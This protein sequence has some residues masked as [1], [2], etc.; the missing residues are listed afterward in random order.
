M[1]SMEEEERP[2]Q[3]QQ[4]QQQRKASA[5]RKR[6]PLE[7]ERMREARERMLATYLNR[8]NVD[9][10]RDDVV[11]IC[12][13]LKTGEYPPAP[14]PKEAPSMVDTEGYKR[15]MRL[16]YLRET[17]DNALQVVAQRRMLRTERWQPFLHEL[18][19]RSARICIVEMFK[20]YTLRADECPL[21]KVP[22]EVLHTI[23]KFLV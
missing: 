7:R 3:Q 14:L 8:L 19:P 18:Y 1:S 4:Q 21:S 2:V 23:F 11:A 15:Y 6:D 16:K 22:R 9:V 17:Y 10:I 5:P 13:E 20:I 12:P